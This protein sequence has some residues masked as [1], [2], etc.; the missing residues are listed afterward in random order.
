M[1]NPAEY[2]Y[3]AGGVSDALLELQDHRAGA[4][5]DGEPA[6]GGFRVGGGGLTVGPYEDG[7]AFGDVLE[8]I[9]RDQAFFVETGEFGLIVHNCAKGI[10]GAACAE[11]FLCAGYGTDYSSAEAGAGVCLYFYHVMPGVSS[12]PNLPWRRPSIHTSSSWRVMWVLS[13]TKAS[14]AC[15]RGEVSR[16]ES[17]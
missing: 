16:W 7:A 9:H 11:V 17:M 15:L 12:R 5:Y 3:L 10:E 2:Y 4:V 14:S 6:R 1:S 13:R 8:G